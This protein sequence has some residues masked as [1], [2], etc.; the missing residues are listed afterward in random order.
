MPP[1]RGDHPAADHEDPVVAAR[2]EALHHDRRIDL[3]GEN[4]GPLQ[5][6]AGDEVHRHTPALIAVPRLH[7]DGCADVLRDR[8]GIRGVV[9]GP[10]LWNG[11]PRLG[12]QRPGEFLVLGDGLR[13]RAGAVGLGGAD[14]PLPRPLAEPHERAG[15]EPLRGDA[16][17]DRRLDDRAGAGAEL[18]VEE[19]L[20]QPLH[21]AGHVVRRVLDGGHD[22]PMR[23]VEALDR[24]PLLLV[25]DHDL[26]DAA[27]LG[28][29]GPA[30]AHGRPGERLQFKGHMLEHVPHPRSG[31]QPLE[32]AAALA[33]RAAVLDHR[34]QPR[35]DPLVEPRQRVRRKVLEATEIDPRLQAGKRRP[36]VGTAQNLDRKNLHGSGCAR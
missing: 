33:D 23:R 11:D 13:D 32:E 14:P 34:R 21:L 18:H 29:A 30:I 17:A 9:D 5:L 36:L 4:P 35:H 25:F 28:L 12:Q 15:R 1:G 22:Q 2:D 8:P 10:P 16:T 24:E 3:V 27:G 26:V 20:P 7:H 31:P 19:H 6:V